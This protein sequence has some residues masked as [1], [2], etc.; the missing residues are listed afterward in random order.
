[1]LASSSPRRRDLMEKLGVDFIIVEPSSDESSDHPDP[2]IRVIMNAELKARSVSGQFSDA[3]IIGADTIVFLDGLFLGKPVDQDDAKKMLELLSGKN[4]QVYTGLAILNTSTGK[5]L[6]KVSCTDVRFKRLS[7]EVIDAYV[8]S[9]EPL[10]KAGAY[11]I[12]GDGRVF[13]ADIV[14][15]YSNVVGL[16]LELLR[17]MLQ[18]SLEKSQFGL[19]KESI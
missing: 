16:P 2:R 9:R 17:E 14:G 10:D 19:S 18:I 3:V 15:S 7:Q 6:S 12:Q 1:M 8:A 5:M 13:I 11:G 4:H